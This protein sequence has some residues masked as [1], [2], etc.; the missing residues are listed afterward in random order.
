MM[1]AARMGHLRLNSQR[2]RP[3]KGE[4]T[5]MTEISRRP[6]VK[7]LKDLCIKTTRDSR[8]AVLFFLRTDRSMKKTLS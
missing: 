1:S 8:G 2:L 7:S 4:E 5:R 3:K 6:Q